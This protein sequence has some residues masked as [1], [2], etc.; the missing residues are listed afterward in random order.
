MYIGRIMHTDLI[1]VSPDTSLVEAKALVAEKQIDHLLVV[2]DKKKL[3]GIVSDRD[4]KKYWASPATSLST[5]ELNYLLQQVLVSMIMVKTVVTVPT[6]TTIERAALIMQQHHISALP[7]MEDD[8]LVGII[9]SFDVV[10]VLLKAI[11]I[12][13]DSVRLG[14]FVVD[15]MGV[16]AQVSETLRDAE[17]NILSLFCWPEN[18]HPGITQLL[19]RVSLQDEAK[20]IEALNA[21]GFK[22]KNRYEKDIT[23]FLPK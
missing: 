15:S 2:D 13:D 10:E 9:T 14:V 18:D 4:L 5:H 1:T 7:V 3:V 23:P 17:I 19:I 16:L 21:K 20:T 11:G 22:V 12:S 8:E 6:S